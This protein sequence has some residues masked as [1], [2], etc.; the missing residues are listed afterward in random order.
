MEIFQNLKD[1]KSAE[2]SSEELSGD[3]DGVWYCPYCHEETSYLD[4][5]YTEDISGNCTINRSWDTDNHSPND[6]NNFEHD[7]DY[8]CPN[9]SEELSDEDVED[10]FD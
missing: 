2:N 7:A 9:C 1:M 8:I 4:C 10:F 5:G 3:V 6:S